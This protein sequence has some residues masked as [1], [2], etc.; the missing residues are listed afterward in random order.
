M[1]GFQLFALYS[2]VISANAGSSATAI[3][4][5]TAN[6]VPAAS[7]SVTDTISLSQQAANILP[8]STAG[9]RDNSPNSAFANRVILN[10]TDRRTTARFSVKSS[11][12]LAYDISMPPHV[13]VSNNK[14]SIT[15]N[16]SHTVNAHGQLNIDEVHELKIGGA[17]KDTTAQ[18]TGAYHGLIDITVNYN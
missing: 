12:N 8:I 15:A 3:T 9:H 16:I 18:N 4:T 17:F 7:F 10:T 5:I 1:N 14:S 11:Q 13:S 2:I 6:I